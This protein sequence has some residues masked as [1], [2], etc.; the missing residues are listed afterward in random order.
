MSGEVTYDRLQVMA[1]GKEVEDGLIARRWAQQEY[2]PACMTAEALEASTDLILQ[3]GVNAPFYYPF[4]GTTDGQALECDPTTGLIANY[5]PTMTLVVET[6]D[7]ARIGYLI[8]LS[9]LM[10]TVLL[11]CD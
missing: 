5:D 7:I 6:P 1:Y 8:S 3:G 10:M 2:L 9:A 4:L 11:L